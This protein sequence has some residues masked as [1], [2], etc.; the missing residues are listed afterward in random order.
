MS[1]TPDPANPT[2]IAP[3]LPP[4]RR[5]WSPA[6]IA[7]WA[8]ILIVVA[9]IAFRAA[10]SQRDQ[11]AAIEP[12]ITLP[13]MSQYALGV[14][15]LYTQMDSAATLDAIDAKLLSELDRTAK[16]PADRFRV[17]ILAGELQGPAEALARMKSLADEDP[18]LAPDLATA[19]DLY[20]GRPAPPDAWP[21]FQSKYRWFADLLAATGKPAADPARAAA[22]AQAW[23]TLFA[24]VITF[25]AAAL[26]AL[27]GLVLL[28]IALVRLARDK[29]KLAFNPMEATGQRADRRA[30][31]VGM[32]IYLGGFLILGR[33]LVWALQ[34]LPAK[35]AP[36]I[37]TNTMAYLAFATAFAL[38]AIIPL[39]LGQS[40]RQWKTTL[41]LTTGRGI[42]REIAGGLL[43][44]LAGMPLMGLGIGLVLVLTK[45]TGIKG[46]HPI[47][48]ELQGSPGELAVVFFLACVFAPVT[49]ELMFR[50]AL[51]AHL[52]ERFPWWIAAPAMAVLF[53][54]MHP[55]SWIA[56]PVLAA[57]AIVFAGIREWRG[58]IIGCMAAHAVHNGLAL[59]VAV[60]LLR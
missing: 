30:Y 19:S 29:L 42:L 26:L 40:W 12:E 46:T 49:E 51:F 60:T 3:P 41:G 55:Q 10:A 4:A 25:A 7:A 2:T 17:A 22:L 28:I 32:A 24:L 15:L 6:E 11:A 14:H 53:A 1:T 9:F 52:R 43:G 23:R 47:V 16:T 36:P 48:H 27:A 34:H 59:A 21:A 50:G 35:F 13:M 33:S 37:A 38:G 8:V 57:I 20:A 45:I 39:L 5:P 31:A 58:S 44:Y 54:L 18:S 56:L